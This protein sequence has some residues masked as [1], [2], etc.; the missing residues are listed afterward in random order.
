MVSFEL[1]ADLHELPTAAMKSFGACENLHGTGFAARD[2]E[3]RESS[4]R[5]GYV[6]HTGEANVSGLA[7]FLLAKTADASS[8]RIA[9]DWYDG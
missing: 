6:T 3:I 4:I 7:G 5:H 2:I 8:R 9:K 1:L